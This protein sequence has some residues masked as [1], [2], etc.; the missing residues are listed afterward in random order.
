MSDPRTVDAPKPSG[1]SLE[2]TNWV[3]IVQNV[4]Q[5]IKFGTVQ[6]IVHNGKVVQIDITEKTRLE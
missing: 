1:P 6:I 2:K 4:V 3:E 5:T